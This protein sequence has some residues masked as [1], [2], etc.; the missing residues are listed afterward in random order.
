MPLIRKNVITV[1]VYVCA[2]MPLSHDIFDRDRCDVHHAGRRDIDLILSRPMIKPQIFIYALCSQHNN[3]GQSTYKRVSYYYASIPA[4]HAGTLRLSASRSEE[5]TFCRVVCAQKHRS[6]EHV[7][8]YFP[9]LVRGR[10]PELWSGAAIVCRQPVRDGSNT[11][12]KEPTDYIIIHTGK[13]IHNINYAR[14]TFRRKKLFKMS[15]INYYK[16]FFFKYDFKR[17]SLACHYTIFV[18]VY[19]HTYIQT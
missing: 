12:N 1:R 4:V 2:T 10:D 3:D 14:T 11:Q 19:I 9:S 15:L 16:V 18:Y 6:S 13:T 17:T 5:S 7:C 8:T